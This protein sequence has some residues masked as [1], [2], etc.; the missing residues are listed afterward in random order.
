MTRK[1]ASIQKIKELVAIDGA[2]RIELALVL[3]WQVVVKKG[4]FKVN[5]LVVFFEIDSWV[6]NT[7]A[8]FLSG[9]KEPKEFNGIKGERLKTIKL[10][11][12]LSQGLVLPVTDFPKLPGK[13]AQFD[14]TEGT[15]ITELLSIQKWEMPEKEARQHTP[16]AT[17]EKRFP[18][19]IRKTDQ[20]RIQNYGALVERALDEEFEVTVKKD[21]SSLT[22]FRVDV[23][24]P[25]YKDALSATQKRLSFTQKVIYTI[26]SLFGLQKKEPVYGICSRNVLLPL[27]GNSNFHKG[28]A[29]LLATLQMAERG[30]WAIQAELVAPDI[31]D[32]YEK[33]TEVETHV[34]DLYDIDNQR[35]ALPY[36]RASWAKDYN[37]KQVSL[38]ASDKLRTI[39]GYK[40]GDDIV[41]KC[42]DFAEGPGDNPGVK[43]EGVV[44]KAMQRDFSFKAVSNSYLLAT[45]K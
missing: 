6:P 38:V 5:D 43:R 16:G 39:I 29:P 17:G 8:P 19:F 42:L 31:Q 15:D 2:D 20:E 33:V 4:D 12:Q 32:N 18:A 14:L 11:K 35:Y 23:D 10:R 36:Q 28:A 9:E 3:G 26:K 34:F 21:G 7:I 25:Y 40:D 24:S 45:G 22:V 41:K 30:S 1:L 37:I 44:F 27:E 13:G